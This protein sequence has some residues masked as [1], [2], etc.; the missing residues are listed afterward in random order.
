MP[1]ICLSCSGKG[2]LGNWGNLGNLGE[3]REFRDFGEFGVLVAG[4]QPPQILY[5]ELG[6]S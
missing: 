1:Q 3:F 4:E 5:Q 2:T 6:V